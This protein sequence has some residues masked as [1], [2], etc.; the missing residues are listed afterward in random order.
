LAVKGT[1]LPGAWSYLLHSVI[2][3]VF[4]LLTLRWS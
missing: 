2:L 3:E 4:V 1:L